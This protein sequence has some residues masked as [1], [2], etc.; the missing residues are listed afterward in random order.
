[1]LKFIPYSIKKAII[2]EWL[3]NKAPDG[4]VYMC[5]KVKFGNN[6]NLVRFKPLREKAARLK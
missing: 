5:V 4:K 2:N 1:M 6:G 3:E